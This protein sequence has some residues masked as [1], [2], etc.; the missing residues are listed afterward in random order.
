MQGHSEVDAALTGIER[1][2]YRWGRLLNE[3][4]FG[5]RVSGAWGSIFSV[6]WLGATIRP[7]Y[8]IDGLEHLPQ[9]SMIVV[10][11]HRTFFDL[12]AVMIAIWHH[13]PQSP[14]LYCPVR[15][16]YFYDHPM[17]PFLNTL[18][19]GNAMYPPIFRDERGP[20]L[21]R[22]AVD[23]CVRLLD[24]QSR[25]VIAMHPEGTRSSN[26]DPY[27][28]LPA[29]PGVGRIAL[30]SRAPVLPIFVNG[31][32]RTFGRLVRACDDRRP[33]RARGLVRP[34]RGACGGERGRAAHARR[35]P[36]AGRAR[37]GLD[38]NVA[39][40]RVEPSG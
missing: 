27:D 35:H 28:L 31:L 3:T 33:C 39:T 16:N 2:A 18:V 5:K 21:N 9:R 11:N 24:W 26:P 22:S 17:G 40:G 23:A 6:P 34:R 25:V 30:R 4:P 36:R 13:L 20:V 29:K 32:P 10:A 38:V 14:W 37:P 1:Y 15:S 12:Y 7:R 8:H 19:S